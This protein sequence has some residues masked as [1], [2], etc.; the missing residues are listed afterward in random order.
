VP[1]DLE[2]VELIAEKL[3]R[4][5]FVSILKEMLQLDQEKRIDP[6][7]A[8]KHTF[9]T[10]NHLVD[11]A[12]LNSV[13]LS[14]QMMEVCYKKP[15]LNDHNHA[16]T[17]AA[18][19]SAALMTN[20]F[21]PSSSNPNTMAALTFNGSTGMPFNATQLNQNIQTATRE[22]AY[23]PCIQ[24]PYFTAQSNGRNHQMPL[25][26]FPAYQDSS[27]LLNTQTAAAAAAMLSLPQTLPSCL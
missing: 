6:D 1:N 23:V 12:H 20:A 7:S 10:L 14:F 9:V 5:A 17:L 19:Q 8:L 24:A 3:D 4:R 26:I 16:V 15:R 27:S 21:M 22:L 18:S 13:R 11:Y 2:G 25:S